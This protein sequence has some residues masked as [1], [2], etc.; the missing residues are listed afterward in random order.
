LLATQRFLPTR[1]AYGRALTGQVRGL[2]QGLE[3]VNSAQIPA[4]DREL[5][6]SRG[7][8]YMIVWSRADNWVRTFRDIDPSAD[9]DPGLYWFGGFEGD[10]GLHRFAGHFPYFITAVE[11]V[12]SAR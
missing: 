4:G 6:F 10:R 12:F 2:Q 3:Q 9:D 5:V 11:G 7:L 8:P 1:T